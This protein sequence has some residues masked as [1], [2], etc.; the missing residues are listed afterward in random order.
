MKNT[1]AAI[2]VTRFGMGAR[3][4]EIQAIGSDARGWLKSQISA[5]QS[6]LIQDKKL[7]SSSDVLIYLGTF[8]QTGRAMI[9]AENDADAMRSKTK[10]VY[11]EIR[12]YYEAEI[13]ARNRHA[14]STEHGFTERWVRFW[15]NHFTVAR[16]QRELVGLVGPHEREAIR[17]NVYGTFENLLLSATFHPAMLRYLDNHKSIGPNTRRGRR[18][19]NGL[20]ENLAREIL[21]LHTLGVG[22]GYT[23]ADI[24]AF[25]K[26][27]TGWTIQG[28]GAGRDRGL[29]ED[30]AVL[31]REALHEPGSQ[32]ILGQ[33]YSGD[34]NLQ[35]ASVLSGLAKHP[36]TAEHIAKKLVQHFVSDTPSGSD[37]ESLSK[38]FIK[39]QGDL[40]AL[41]EAVIDLDTAWSPEPQK[42]KTPEELLISAARL[43]GHDVVFS[44]RQRSTYRALGQ[45]PFTAPAPSGWADIAAEWAN[46]DAIKKRLEWANKLSQLASRDVEGE[47]FL[48]S[49]LGDLLSETTLQA[50]RR[51]ESRRQALTLAL[52]SPEFQ[53]R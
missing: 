17:P 31:F 34:A 23:Q 28:F 37:V 51:A 11:G 22:S 41:A 36:S 40:S 16:R 53:R 2:A 30:K 8:K 12:T 27:L 3:S 29:D 9:K 50:V 14:V 13:Q 33:T 45:T 21:E 25:A 20:N 48:K 39:T 7:K 38:V 32:K 26:T 5:P 18:S 46:P 47:A 6:A 44:K 49:G 42:F 52:M 10:E 15:S 4:G 35:A 43:L 19:R 1:N 24:I